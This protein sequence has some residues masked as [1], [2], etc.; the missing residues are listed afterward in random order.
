MEE[1]P[2]LYAAQNGQE[3]VTLLLLE[4][5]KVNP[6]TKDWWTRGSSQ[7]VF[8]KQQGRP[9]SFGFMGNNSAAMSS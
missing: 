4:C 9:R 3:A 5:K 2:L 6:H 1:T 7:V 8:S